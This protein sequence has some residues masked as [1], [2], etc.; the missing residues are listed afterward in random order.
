MEEKLFYVHVACSSRIIGLLGWVVGPWLL[1][2]FHC[3]HTCGQHGRY[4]PSPLIPRFHHSPNAT[5][6]ALYVPLPTWDHSDKLTRLEPPPTL[7]RP[8]IR[9][10]DQVHVNEKP[11][12]DLVSSVHTIVHTLFHYPILPS[13]QSFATPFCQANPPQPSTFFVWTNVWTFVWALST[14]QRTLSVKKNSSREANFP[15]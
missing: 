15:I 3:V 2:Y 1:R 11:Q 12:H 4:R 9:T 8:A 13:S 7:L 10:V 6:Q 5:L 14:P